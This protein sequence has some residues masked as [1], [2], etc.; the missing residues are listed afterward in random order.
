MVNS[1][2]IRETEMLAR[3]RIGTFFNERRKYMDPLGIIR[4]LDDL[5][6][7]IIGKKHRK[8]KSKLLL[9][10]EYGGITEALKTPTFEAFEKVKCT[11]RV[12]LLASCLTEFSFDTII[13]NRFTHTFTEVDFANSS[14]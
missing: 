1:S 14:V 13:Q 6:K 9:D 7:N 8:H 4:D 3:A 5:S 12:I 11:S 10:Y 2:S